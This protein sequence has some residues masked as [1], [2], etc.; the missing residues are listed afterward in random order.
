MNKII[1]KTKIF[2]N[3]SS[4]DKSLL[5][6]YYKESPNNIVC[7]IGQNDSD[8]DS[9]LSSDVGINL[10][11]PTNMN[12]ILCHF[13]S[14]NNDILCI[15]NVI[16]QGKLFFENTIILELVSF[17]TSVINNG[18]I[19]FS[20]LRNVVIN[21][22]E[23][24]FLKIEFLLFATL[25]FLGKTKR[26]IDLNNNDKLLNFYY[27]LLIGETLIIK[28]IMVIYF[29][30]TYSG[31]HQFE[32]H[33]RDLNVLSNYFVL[34]FE[35]LIC[36]IVSINLMPFNRE[37]VISNYYFMFCL[38]IYLIYLAFLLFLNSS[39]FSF[40]ILSITKFLSNEIIMDCFEDN[41][42]LKLVGCMVYDFFLT[43]FINWITSIIVNLVIKK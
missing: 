42:R 26:D 2:F 5:V 24:N 7:V 32:T 29:G 33:L 35:F 12:T 9:I 40:D 22:K 13:Y 19:L 34:S 36:C 37:S 31:D 1:Q 6:D 39:N 4:I 3:M 20:L 30:I 18:Y 25:S 17:I 27:N 23:F 21:R 11:K 15:I 8:I 38:F 14:L 28:I 16:M 41:F 10:K 43:L